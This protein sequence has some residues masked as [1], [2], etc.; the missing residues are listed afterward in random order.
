MTSAAIAG[1]RRELARQYDVGFVDANIEVVDV[2]LD[3]DRRLMLRHT[4]VKGAQLNET[5]TRRVLQHLADL[6]TYDVVLTEVDGTDKVLK[7]YVVSPRAAAAVGSL[8]ARLPCGKRERRP[9]AA[10]WDLVSLD[11]R[12]RRRSTSRT[13]S[14]TFS[15]H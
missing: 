14:A 1:C 9:R 8:S 11:L 13:F 4:T 10:E 3:G 2:D 5:D 7:E 15:R 6:W 12:D